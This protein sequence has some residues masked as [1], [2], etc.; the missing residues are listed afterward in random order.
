MLPLC[1]HRLG[2]H[3]TRIPAT[4]D[5]LPALEE[6]RMSFHSG[7]AW[8]TFHGLKTGDGRRVE[9]AER[10]GGEVLFRRGHAVTDEEAEP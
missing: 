8:V 9:E 2:G 5:V 3:R 10:R 7:I 1:R 6:L 4:F